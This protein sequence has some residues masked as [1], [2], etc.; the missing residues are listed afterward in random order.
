MTGRCRHGDNRLKNRPLLRGHQRGP[1]RPLPGK[2]EEK[3]QEGCR[4]RTGKVHARRRAA[5]PFAGEHFPGF[6][7]REHMRQAPTTPMHR[8]RWLLLAMASLGAGTAAGCYATIPEATG[9]S[10][11]PSEE[12]SHGRMAPSP[13]GQSTQPCSPPEDLSATRGRR[14]MQ[15]AAAL[16]GAALTCCFPVGTG[17]QRVPFRVP[18]GAPPSVNLVEASWPT[19]PAID[20]CVERIVHAWRPP[21]PPP[22]DL[23]LQRATP[24]TG[25]CEANQG[26]WAGTLFIPA[27]TDHGVAPRVVHPYP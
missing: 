7:I 14:A 25:A 16:A 17:P 5:R 23:C 11:L 13:T 4:K 24:F 10:S 20:A 19:T 12:L 3:V 8:F 6:A 21:P 27:H 1:P 9:P 2:D 22:S 15:R 18:T 26:L